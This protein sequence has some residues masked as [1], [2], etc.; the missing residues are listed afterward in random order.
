MKFKR[1]EFGHYYDPSKYESCPHCFART[2]GMDAEYTVAKAPIDERVM[3]AYDLEYDLPDDAPIQA[4]S[5]NRNGTPRA[6]TQ[7]EATPAPAMQPRPA[8]MPAAPAAQ[9]IPVTPADDESV[10]VAR[11]EMQTGIDPVVGWLVQVSGS[12]K[13]KAYDIHSERNTIGRSS[14][15]HI[16]IKGDVGISRDTNGVLS[17]NPRNRSFHII[18]GEGK[19]IIYVND[20]ELLAP[21]ELY[22]YDRIEISDTA[23][24]FIPLC[25]E[26][27]CWEDVV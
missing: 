24:L 19:A 1:C 15:M 10:T 13:G 17:Y 16:C 6:A 8:A 3:Q 23:L 20:Q 2:S 7:Y 22:A 4:P 14:A 5:R 26:K 21:M 18:P 9:V 12:N 11:M 27:F 25:G